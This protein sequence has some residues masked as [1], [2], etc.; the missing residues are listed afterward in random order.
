MGTADGAAVVG[1]QA[2]DIK[3]GDWVIICFDIT[4]EE[5]PGYVLVQVNNLASDENGFTEPEPEDGDSD[6]E[7]EL[8]EK[9]LATVWD[10]YDDSGTR[11]GL[12]TLDIVT[13]NAASSYPDAP[14]IS[15]SWD[16]SR[17][18]GG[19]V[20]SDIHYTSVRETYEQWFQNGFLLGPGPDSDA[21]KIGGPSNDQDAKRVYLLLEVPDT[22]GNEIQGDSVEFDLEFRA[23]QVRNNDNPFPGPVINADTG[24]EFDSIQAAIDDPDTNDGDTIRVREGASF[25]EA[26]D[27]GVEN[28]T[29]EAISNTK[30]TIEQGVDI[31]ADGVTVDGFEIRN[32][33]TQG[34][35]DP[36]TPGGL[37]GV[38]VNSG[39]Q[40]ASIRNNDITEVGTNDD[41]ANPIGVLASDGTTGITVEGNEISNLEGTDEDQGQVQGVLINESGTQITD[42]TVN[43]NTITGLLD[44]RSTN[45]VRFNGDVKGEIIGNTISDLNTEGTI[46]GSGGAPG[47]FTQVIALQQ[48]GGSSTGP[49]EVTIENNTISDI[50]T[51]TADN[52]APPFHV[53]LGGSTD[54]TTVTIDSNDFSGDSNDDEVYVGDGSGGLTLN[55]ILSDNSF[56]PSGSI[57][58]SEIVRQ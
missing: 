51:T 33:G 50:E 49:S 3:P 28:L 22:V 8:D 32:P 11:S 35:A 4:I 6:G 53:I 23:E 46:P 18:E 10:D 44:T 16:S 54:G 38:H 20:D 24:E 34:S 27:I 13:N 19:E 9:L 45:A 2:E 30:P 52:F 12:S 42:A 47:G 29:L 5:N 31:R 1:L 15:H 17:N 41:D 55:D 14:S 37:V 58:G 39:N 40:N 57:Q 48:G 25:D 26:V 36:G 43:N 56:T 7:G 21:S